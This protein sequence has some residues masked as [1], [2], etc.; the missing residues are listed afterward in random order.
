MNVQAAVICVAILNRLNGDQVTATPEQ[1]ADF[2]G[3]PVRAVARF[4]KQDFDAFLAK[5]EAEELGLQEDIK[6]INSGD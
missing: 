6:K 2:E 1:L 4:I 5:M 3:R